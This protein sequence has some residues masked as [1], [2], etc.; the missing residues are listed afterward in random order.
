MRACCRHSCWHGNATCSNVA[1]ATALPVHSG[2][3][4]Y[5]ALVWHCIKRQR[6][7]I[8]YWK[9][10]TRNGQLALENLHHVLLRS[11]RPWQR[12][13]AHSY[14]DKFNSSKWFFRIMLQ[15]FGYGETF[16]LFWICFGYVLDMFWIINITWSGSKKKLTAVLHELMTAKSHFHLRG[17]SLSSASD[18]L[19]FFQYITWLEAYEVINKENT[20]SIYKLVP[21][22]KNPPEVL[23]EMQNW[24]LH[25]FLAQ[26]R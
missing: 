13:C 2:I 21:T 25:L 6:W 1:D 23:Q 8:R 26:P 16:T 7:G 22:I 14:V 15:C 17:S 11:G 20:I 12:L 5:T 10:S 24:K 4:W 19:V 9:E 3:V 18:C